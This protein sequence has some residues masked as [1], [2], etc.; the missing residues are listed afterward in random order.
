[1]STLPEQLN[2]LN[3]SLITIRFHPTD[4]KAFDFFYNTIF[5]SNYVYKCQV[6]CGTIEYDKTLDRHLHFVLGYTRNE[7]SDNDR[8]RRDLNGMKN[9]KVL[10]I[11]NTEFESCG[12]NCK[13]L[14]KYSPDKDE[15]ED[16]LLKDNFIKSVA[17][18]KSIG[19]C[20]KEDNKNYITNVSK[21]DLEKSYQA[22]IF[23]CKKHIGLLDND[24]EYKILTVG[25]L[26][27]YMYDSFKKSDM[28][29]DDL[30]MLEAYM[31]QHHK[32]CFLKITDKQKTQALKE[33]EL[34]ITKNPH[35]YKKYKTTTE[36]F[37]EQSMSVEEEFEC[38][39]NSKQCMIKE[40]I[41]LRN[42]LKL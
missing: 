4:M 30:P 12:I 25:N 2:Q 40:I 31:I 39:E 20:L 13:T 32:L 10:K 6:Y 8:L 5:L 18:M 14:N 21:K 24:L 42:K 36:E 16:K 11:K 22:Y 9:Y 1:M 28:D 29:L 7:W 35:E 19:Y 37:I 38:F 26:L 41:Y 27:S 23:S 3:F 33:L 17:V 15:P 34:H